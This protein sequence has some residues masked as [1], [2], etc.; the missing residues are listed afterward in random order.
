MKPTAG[1]ANYVHFA[2]RVDALRLGDQVLT[3]AHRW[4]TVT[5]LESGDVFS[6]STRVTTDATGAE[7]PWE[8]VDQHLVLARRQPAGPMPAVAPTGRAA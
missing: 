4:E 6:K 7:Y 8:W 1:S 3:P 5:A 2:C